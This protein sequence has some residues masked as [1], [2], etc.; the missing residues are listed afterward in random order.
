MIET[1]EKHK[2]KYGR[3]LK[4][5][6]PYVDLISNKIKNFSKLERIETKEPTLAQI[7]RSHA[8]THHDTETDIYNI[9]LR[10]T[11]L[12]LV[13]LKPLERQRKFFTKLDILCTL[14]HELAHLDHWE[15]SPEHKQLECE[16]T[17]DFM[18]LLKE[19][20]YISDEQD[21]T[22]NVIN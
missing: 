8:I 1:I 3:K 13:T 22:N 9:V 21:Y 16:L 7:S 17:I 11:Y 4:W 6:K 14:A 20:G 10:T 15:H 12:E 2:I 18:K 19:S 5:I